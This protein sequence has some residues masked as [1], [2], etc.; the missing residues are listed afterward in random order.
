MEKFYTAQ[1]V[2][3]FLK[4]KKTTVYELIKKKKL[5]SSKVG[6]Q[7]RISRTDLD[8]Y[9]NYHDDHTGDSDARAAALQ[10]VQPMSVT[11]AADSALLTQDYLRNMSGL[12]VSGQEELISVFCA[13]YQLEPEHLPIIQ[14]SLNFYDSLYALYFEKVHAAFTLLPR[15]AT[16]DRAQNPLTYLVP[17]VSLISVQAAEMTCGI[18]IKKENSNGIHTAADLAA[19]GICVMEGVKGSIYRIILDECLKEAGIDPGKLKR[20]PH[21]SI[22]ALA[23]AA[24][25][26]SGQAEA[27]VGNSNILGQFPDLVFI[28]LK[29]AD[30]KLVFPKKFAQHPAFQGM[31]HVLQSDIFKRRLMQMEGYGST[32]TG[33]IMIV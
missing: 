22:S 11:D 23:A 6:K 28:P 14:H 21:E 10:T 9:L 31:I 3:D 4:I 1:E 17:G 15:S 26:D 29:Q 19:S 8:E 27:A 16:Q 20:H 25:V 18:Y 5:P 2:A 24:A 12:I 7:L 33:E 13:H 30:L 32:H